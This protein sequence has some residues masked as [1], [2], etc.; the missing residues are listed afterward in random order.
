MLTPPVATHQLFD[1]LFDGLQ[2]QDP[3]LSLPAAGCQFACRIKTTYLSALL[4]FH[5][6]HVTTYFLTDTFTWRT[7]PPIVRNLYITW[8]HLQSHVVI[9][10]EGCSAGRG[11]SRRK[12]VWIQSS[13]T[14][15][16]ARFVEPRARALHGKFP[17]SRDVLKSHVTCVTWDLYSFTCR[18]IRYLRP[19]KVL[20]DR[21]L[22][23]S[24]LEENLLRAYWEFCADFLVSSFTDLHSQFRHSSFV[25]AHSSLILPETV[26]DIWLHAYLKLYHLIFM[27]HHNRTCFNRCHVFVFGTQ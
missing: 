13:G 7:L 21:Y 23:G 1:G 4:C 12:T 10:I 25:P 22:V 24:L 27:I 19:N 9:P 6:H 2:T 11:V 15:N 26:A 5:G 17:R 18:N 16:N 3:P 20:N 8:H 14:P